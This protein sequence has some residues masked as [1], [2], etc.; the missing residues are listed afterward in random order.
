MSNDRLDSCRV[1]LGDNDLV[2]GGS[3]EMGET[4][5]ILWHVPLVALAWA[6]GVVSF[7]AGLV[8]FLEPVSL[9]A[10]FDWLLDLF[11]PGVLIMLG[12]VLIL[13]GVWLV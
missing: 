1:G 11:L 12:L 2:C 9:R 8:G 6:V 7:V 5:M 10:P 13:V 3:V 4:S